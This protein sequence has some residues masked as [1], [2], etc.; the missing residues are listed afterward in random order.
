MSKEFPSKEA[1]EKLLRWLNSDRDKAGEKYERIR[2]R[3]IRIF[4]VR[5]CCEVEDLAD[6]TINVVAARIDWLLENYN[7]DPTL[8]FY[9]VARKIYL[10]QLKKKPPPAPPPAPDRTEIEQ[11][12]SCLERCLKRELTPLERRMALRYYEKSKTEKIVSRKQLASELGISMNALRIKM[13]YIVG[14][15]RPCVEQCLRHLHETL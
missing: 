7:G 11:H 3:L 2:L 5:G 15:L 9:G 8:Y 10:E 14:R 1:F 4:A 6:E 12:C 13:H